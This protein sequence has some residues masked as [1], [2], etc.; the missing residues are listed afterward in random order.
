MLFVHF[1]LRFGSLVQS[2]S[3]RLAMTCLVSFNIVCVVFFSYT[4]T[5]ATA[6]ITISF[7]ANESL[8]STDVH[9]TL[10][11]TTDSEFFTDN[12]T[13][14]H[15]SDR[16]CSSITII[17][18]SLTTGWQSSLEAEPAFARRNFPDSLH[19]SWSVCL[20]GWSTGSSRIFS[21][22]HQRSYRVDGSDYS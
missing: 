5:A 14:I 15:I 17:P 7:S 4:A 12:P 2:D 1:V 21:W 13:C 19:I 10:G 8:F 20:A 3:L 16:L 22:H 6:W 18:L 11:Q 9:F